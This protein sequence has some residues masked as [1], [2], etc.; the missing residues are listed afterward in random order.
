MTTMKPHISPVS[1][2]ASMRC[3]WYSWAYNSVVTRRFYLTGDMTNLYQF[4]QGS[5]EWPFSELFSANVSL[6]NQY[7]YIAFNIFSSRILIISYKI[8]IIAGISN[9][10]TNEL[11]VHGILCWNVTI[12]YRQELV[13]LFQVQEKLKACRSSKLNFSSSCFIAD[14]S[15]IKIVWLHVV[16]FREHDILHFWDN[17]HLFKYYPMKVPQNCFDS[18]SCSN[19]TCIKVSKFFVFT[20]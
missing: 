20:R 18:F 17:V 19:Q 12:F 8:L 10:K 3:F 6:R 9:E 15:H 11:T 16:V 7:K 2:I 1:F 13:S 4:T 14:D 5:L